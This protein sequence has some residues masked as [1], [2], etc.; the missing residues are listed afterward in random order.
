MRNLKLIGKS[1]TLAIAGLTTYSGYNLITGN[2]K[3]YS[4]YAMPLGRLLMD[5]E[6]AHNFA[7]ASFK[8]GL[9]PLKKKLDNEEILNITA[10]NKSFD[11]PLGCAAGFDK[12][13]EAMEG[14]FQTGFGF[15]EIGTITPLPQPGNPKPRVF[16]LVEDRAVINRYGFNSEGRLPVIDRVKQFKAKSSNEKK[17]L[18]I[19]IGKN[20]LS[21][22]AVADYLNGIESFNEYADYMTINI[23]SPNTPGLR[24]LQSKKYLEQLVD[25]I[26]EMRDVKNP[27][28][29]VIVK[30]APDLTDEEMQD[31]AAVLTRKNKS[32]DGVIISNTTI[33]RPSSLK[34]E[35]KKETGGL[36]GRPV[37]EL[38]NK[39]I[40][41][42]Y[43][44][45][46]GKL[47]IIGVGGIE[48]G[49]DALDKIKS[50]ATLVQ[51]YTAMVFE[52]PTLVNRIKRELIDLL[53]QE[54]FKN[55]N[56][57]VGANMKNKLK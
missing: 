17:I 15:V 49:Q 33:T 9:A 30:I 28:M 3:F 29:P 19:N 56:E 2:E 13:G 12:N 26:L 5:G 52:G 45:T 55:V 35:F 32:V 25:P 18:G 40:Q 44:L 6:Q 41:R 10:F 14:L 54:G 4:N 38:S 34:S 24:N 22:N 42:F 50:G 23:S 47:L 36:S 37:K 11:N 48:N 31:I 16:R 57:A 39:A 53:K 43:E 1:V 20:K 7:I 8:Y 46:K 51:I 21:E 27:K